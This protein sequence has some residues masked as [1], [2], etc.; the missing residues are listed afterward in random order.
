MIACL[1]FSASEALA[2]A[3]AAAAW[4]AAEAAASAVGASWRARNL[5]LM[6]RIDPEL[7]ATGG[8]GAGAGVTKREGGQARGEVLPQPLAPPR[9]GALR[10]GGEAAHIH[11]FRRKR[12]IGFSMIAKEKRA[13][14]NP[15]CPRRPTPGPVPS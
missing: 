8:D 1:R 11:F 3:A 6:R 2:A 14:T 7:T 9:V 5:S 15:R 13:S 10:A 12:T 4:L